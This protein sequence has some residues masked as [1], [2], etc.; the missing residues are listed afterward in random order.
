M[1]SV[2]FAAVVLVEILYGWLWCDP[3]AHLL[4][5]ITRFTDRRILSR[6]YRDSIEPAPE[7]AHEAMV[8]TV[9]RVLAQS[10]Y[11]IRDTILGPPETEPRPG[12]FWKFWRHR[13]NSPVSMGFDAGVLAV[14]YFTRTLGWALLVWPVAA[15]G[16]HVV[17]MALL[18][19]L[20][21][22]I[23]ALNQKD[24]DHE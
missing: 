15:A 17:W 16:V 14:L 2:E 20:D 19:R 6:H 4:D 12:P 18:D 10:W 7:G 11:T 23:E 3:S 21:S 8:H 22:I 1:T 9:E 13:R 24:P 5:P